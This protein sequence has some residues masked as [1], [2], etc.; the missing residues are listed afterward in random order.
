MRE[1][2]APLRIDFAGSWTD[3]PHLIKNKTGYVSTATITPHFEYSNKKLFTNGYA[4]GI[5]LCTSTAVEA[6]EL[7]KSNNEKF[8][9]KTL[10]EIAEILFRSENKTLDWAIGRQDAYSITF[11]GFNCFQFKQDGATPLDIQVPKET[12]DQLEENLIL[13]YSGIQRN[14]Q[15][16]TKEIYENFNSKESKYTEAINKLAKYGLDFA[17]NLEKGNLDYCG[18]ILSSN[19]EVQKQLAKSTSNKELNEIYDFAIKNNAIGGKLCGA[20]SGGCFI[21]YTQDKEELENKLS[22]QF[23]KGKVID[24]KFEYKNIKKLNEENKENENSNIP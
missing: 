1:Y 23:P 15:K 13:F 19:W 22:N 11:G 12:L 7:I 14:S 6:I 17:I 4:R 20:G 21:F 5:G 24:F 2:K 9:F 10:E 3:I 8:Q 16:V 18:Q